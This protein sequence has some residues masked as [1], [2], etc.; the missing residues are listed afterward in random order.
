MRNVKIITKMCLK[1]HSNRF[2]CL[3]SPHSAL[4]IF[5]TLLP[6]AYLHCLSLSVL[7]S[8]RHLKRK[9]LVV[10]IWKHVPPPTPVTIRGTEV[11]EDYRYLGYTDSKLDWSKN[12]DIVVKRGKSQLYLLRRLR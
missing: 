3:L 9:Y 5:S 12:M 6:L 7:L 8:G 1:M 10:D 2:D 4:L 11:V